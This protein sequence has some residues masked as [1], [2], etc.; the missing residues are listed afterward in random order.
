[1]LTAFNLQFD[2]HFGKCNFNPIRYW[3]IVEIFMH[4][5]FYKVWVSIL[6][7]TLSD[8]LHQTHLTNEQGKC[9]YNVKRTFNQT[10][11]ET[12]N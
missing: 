2:I 4:K 1:M 6:H 11:E 12:L 9:N 7:Y 8:I 3:F 5:V 10:H